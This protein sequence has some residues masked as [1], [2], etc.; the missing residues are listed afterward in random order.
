MPRHGFPTPKD[1]YS[2]SVEA[3]E[4]VDV[5]SSINER[6]LCDIC[7]T[8]SIVPEENLYPMRLMELQRTCQ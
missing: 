4:S 2:N 1:A 8:P 6:W 7:T 5:I 3:E